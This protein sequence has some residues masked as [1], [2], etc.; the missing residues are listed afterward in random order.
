M[1]S[2]VKE[3][4]ATMTTMFEARM[5]AGPD[6]YVTDQET[7][8]RRPPVFR[9][10]F[11][12][13]SRPRSAKLIVSAWGLVECGVNGS[14]VGQDVL[15]P[16]WTVYGTRLPYWTYDV[17]NLIGDGSNS[18]TFWLGD[19]WYR[20]KIGFNGGKQDYYGNRLGLFVEPTVDSRGTSV[21][22]MVARVA[23]MPADSS[24]L[25]S[26]WSRCSTRRV[27]ISSANWAS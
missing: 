16:G 6:D 15:T 9:R 8:M 22:P 18:L 26:P 12:V 2:A 10:D 5:I 17:T 25:P 19:G 11:S 1:C 27:I 23:G 4:A 21:Y 14:T 24:D 13:A 7:G 3:E 20:G